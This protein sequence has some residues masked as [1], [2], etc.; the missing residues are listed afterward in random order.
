MPFADLRKFS[1]IGARRS[2]P[3][4]KGAH[5]MMNNMLRNEQ[6]RDFGAESRR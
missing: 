1:G 4:R 2:R 6:R 5:Y 3:I